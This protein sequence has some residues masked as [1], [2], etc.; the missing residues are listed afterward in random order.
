MSNEKY[1][2]LTAPITDGVT[3]EDATEALTASYPAYKVEVYEQDNEFVAKLARK[4]AAPGKVPPFLDED[5]DAAPD[6]SDGAKPPKEKAA[7]KDDGDDLDGAPDEDAAPPDDD[8]ADADKEPKGDKEDKGDEG[9]KG[10]LGKALKALDTL[11]AVLPKLETQLKSLNGGEMPE[12]L[13]DGPLGPEGGPEGHPAPP[14]AGLPP[15]PSQSA[16]DSIGPTPGKPAPGNAAPMVPGMGG[17]G[18]VPPRPGQLP[19]FSHIKQN[20]FVYRPTVNEDGT[21]ISMADAA[22]EIAAH[23]RYASYD[24]HEVKLDESGD[25]YVAHLKLR[26][27]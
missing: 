16:L 23:P 7:P 11:K 13:G 20:K 26:T 15:G 8:D 3:L 24:V 19:T 9:G 6:D 1:Q 17:H 4:V 25:Q 10:D 21:K 27:E 18:P 22:A 14:G 5:E 2:V 12:G